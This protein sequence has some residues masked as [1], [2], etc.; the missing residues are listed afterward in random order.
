L[1]IGATVRIQ[2]V[3]FVFWVGGCGGLLES[4]EAGNTDRAATLLANGADLNER[5]K[6]GR[7]P[8]HVAARDG[9]EELVRIMLEKGADPNITDR[10]AC[11]PLWYV[12][13]S[14][15][16]TAVS[17]AQ[18]LIEHG[19]EINV[20]CGFAAQTPLI[21]ASASG[22]AELV[23]LLLAH[24][25]DATVLDASGRTAMAWAGERFP[26]LARRMQRASWQ[27]TPHVVPQDDRIGAFQMGAPLDNVFGFC[28]A[29]TKIALEFPP[30]LAGARFDYS[31][32][33]AAPIPELNVPVKIS[34][35][36]S[37]DGRLCLLWIDI[38]VADFVETMARITRS[39]EPLL[40]RPMVDGITDDCKELS[41]FA[42]CLKTGR[43][44]PAFVWQVKT[45]LWILLIADATAPAPLRLLYA[46]AEA[47]ER[48]Q[49]QGSTPAS[50]VP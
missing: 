47:M 12:A 31:G 15:A 42:E 26:E 19:A 3:C 34:H 36:L 6:G 2:I 39:L 40:G 45:G 25:A 13:R 22:N 30:M 32:S 7:G 5:D 10:L 50:A 44:K 24:N 9:H 49:R 37:C 23:Q 21:V 43:T 33:C 27:Q 38:D 8:L 28:P 17:I 16:K 4:I 48:L 29:A 18:L 35:P 11:T 46:N 41:A 1:R 14:A 20:V